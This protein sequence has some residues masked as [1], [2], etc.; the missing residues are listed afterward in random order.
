MNN[1]IINQVATIVENA[2]YNDNNKFGTGIWH[3]HILIVLKYVDALA[4][5]LGAD[6]E[7]CALAALLHDYAGIYNYK[8]YQKHHIHSAKAAQVLLEQ[9]NYPKSKIEQVKDAIYTHRGSQLMH[10]NSI[11]AECLANA[12]AIAHIEGYQSLLNYAH[13][14]KHLNWQ[15]SRQFVLDKINRSWQKMTA[16]IKALFDDRYDSIVN[17]LKLAS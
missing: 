3:D 5:E 4:I 13:D 6:R 10:F 11:E 15:H 14:I 16:R 9:L 8:Y 2:C 17:Q 1:A 12:D 7:I